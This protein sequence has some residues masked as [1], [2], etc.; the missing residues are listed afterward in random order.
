MEYLR[1]LVISNFESD[2]HSGFFSRS[3][4]LLDIMNKNNNNNN[5]RFIFQ[6]ISKT[7]KQ[8][9]TIL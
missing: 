8:H 2:E 4:V 7:E 1:M 5:N 6:V 3:D 9:Q